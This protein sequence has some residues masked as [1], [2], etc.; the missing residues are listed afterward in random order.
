VIAVRKWTSESIMREKEER[1]RQLCT[2]DDVDG[3]GNDDDDDDECV[4]WARLYGG[5]IGSPEMGEGG[6][7]KA[8]E[9]EHE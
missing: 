3:N 9:G 1:K 5:G 8:G 6:G 2:D 7:H 4:L